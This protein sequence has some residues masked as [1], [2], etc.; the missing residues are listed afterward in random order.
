MLEKALSGYDAQKEAKDAKAAKEPSRVG[1]SKKSR[2]A[3]DPH[4]SPEVNGGACFTERIEKQVPFINICSDSCSTRQPS[5]T[6]RLNYTFFLRHSY[7]C[8]A[9]ENLCI[10]C[11]VCSWYE[12]F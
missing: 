1:K 11:Y 12:E 4:P 3:P 10:V 7:F 6:K 5:A 8:S 9:S 2:L